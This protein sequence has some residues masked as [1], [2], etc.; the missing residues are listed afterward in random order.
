MTAVCRLGADELQLV[1]DAFGFVHAT[2]SYEELLEIEG[3]DGVVVATPHSLHYEHTMAALKRGLHVMCEKPLA[4]TADHA[5][6]M[7]EEADRQ[8]VQLL[9]PHGWHYAPVHPKSQRDHGT[10][11]G[12]KHRIRDV[13]HGFP[14]AEPA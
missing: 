10:E 11:S 8:G 4:T 1:K 3:L 2:E 6:A 9:I 12:G 14:G 13:P 7:V 5:R